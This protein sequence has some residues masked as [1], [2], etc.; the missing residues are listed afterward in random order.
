MWQA[1]T[2]DPRRIDQELGWAEGL[3]FN[4][5]R[6]FLHNL[7]WTQDS[8]GFLKRMDQFVDI[9]AR[10]RIKV[11]FVLFDSCWDPHPALGKQR[12]PKPFVHNSGWVQSPGAGFY[13]PS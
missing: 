1:D 2:F 6:V 11:M 10:H 12:A 7:L 5:G 3:G 9:A 8:Q 13:D 4:S